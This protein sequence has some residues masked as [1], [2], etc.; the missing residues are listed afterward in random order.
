MI[1]S[2]TVSAV[3]S[4][5]FD[6]S[7]SELYSHSAVERQK[8]RFTRVLQEFIRLYGDLE[9]TLFSVPGR[10]ELS[11]NHTDHN[12][13]TVLAASVDIDIIA[14]A[15][16]SGDNVV[17]MKSEG[18]REDVV[19]VSDPAHAAVRR[20]SSSSLIA[21][22]ADWFSKNGLEFGGYRACTSSD[23]MSGSGLSSSAAFEVMCGRIISEFYN[24]GAV[25][26]L[27]LARAGKYAENEF[28]GKP[29]G[30]MDQAA[31]ASGGC[32]WID[33]GS[34]DVKTEKIDLDLNSQ[35]YAL[36]IVNTGG[37]HADLTEDYAAV[38][39]EMKKIASLLGKKVLRE[40]D[41][42]AFNARIGELRTRA[43]DRAVLR[44]MHFFAENKRVSAQRDALKKGDF[45]EYLRL[46][47]SSG[48]S[49]FKYLQNVYTNH[50]VTE[51]GISLALA[52]SERFGAVCRVHGGGFA[53]TIQA[54]VPLDRV[55][56]YRAGIEAVFG[57]NACRV[58][59]I[60]RYGASVVTEKGIF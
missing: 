44:A 51:Q 3:R 5:A 60:R 37:N 15:A 13:G 39:A 21:G 28:F 56:D 59:G 10:T 17:R 11:G 14:V 42:D 34:E 6:S 27:D 58:T 50:N 20:G 26:A 9:V 24:K 18:Y 41:E 33:F 52:V 16:P 22:V 54:Y 43:G 36:C 48:D 31:C 4:G 45:R 40:C 47:Q 57:E 29:C 19:D 49:S 1:A 2:Q 53:G 30:L 12:N 7:L 8:E 55:A 46:V 35:G 38:P 32:L 23:V 25:S